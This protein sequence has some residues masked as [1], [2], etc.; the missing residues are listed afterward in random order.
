MTTAS[1]GDIVLVR[2]VFADEKGVK[3]RPGLI[4]SSEPYHRGRREAIIAAI[5]SNVSRRLV[6]DY[7]VK[8]WRESGLLYPSFVTGIIRT[9]KQDMIAGQ[10]GT[11]PAS[12]MRAIDA[13]LRQIL[14]L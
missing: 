2:F 10:M 13:R 6:G 14:G 4:L 8:A 1:R 7:K 12:E 11:L 5:T 9:I 3:Q